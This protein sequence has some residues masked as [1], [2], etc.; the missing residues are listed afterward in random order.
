MNRHRSRL[1]MAELH[2]EFIT[3]CVARGIGAEVAG[4]IFKAVAGF[5][6]ADG[7]VREV[8]LY[9]AQL[10]FDLT[11]RVTAGE[12]NGRNLKQDFVVLSLVNQ[13][14]S[15][16]KAEFVLNPDPR[17]SAIAAWITS[18]NQ[19]EAIQAVG[20]WLTSPLLNH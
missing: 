7:K 15:D 13:K 20:G 9:I 1:E 8:T 11:T 5:A 17:A 14:M 6:P 19:I 18:P 4:E 2:D 16:G 10:G 12:N 3:R